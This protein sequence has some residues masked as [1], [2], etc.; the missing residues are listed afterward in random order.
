MPTILI[1]GGSYVGIRVAHSLLKTTA[2]TVP[3]LKVV[4][5]TKNTHF[6]WNMASVRAV[7]PGQFKE[8]QYA[9]PIAKGFEQYPAGSFELIIGSAEALDID[10][11]TV[12]IKVGDAEQPC[13]YD[14]LVLATGSR[15]TNA[16]VPWKANGTY[17]EVAAS[18]KRTQDRIAEAKEIIIAGAGATGIELAGEIAFEYGKDKKVTLLSG[19]EKI[20]GGDAVASN[21][22]NEL[23]K[24]G[25]SIKTSAR[26]ANTTTLTDGTGKTEVT[27][28]N[29]DKLVTDLYLPT[30][31]VVPNSEYIPDKLLN[32]KKLVAVDETY[33]VTGATDV[34]AAGDVVAK[35][36]AT[37]VLADAQA[38]GVAKN[39][40]LVLKGKNPGS[41]SLM[42]F[43][44]TVAAIGRNRGVGRLGVVKLFSF[45][46]YQMK[47]KTLGVERTQTW[48]DGSAF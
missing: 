35:P 2:K 20:L 25:V 32:D 7:I 36:K 39:L 24:L 48:V 18:I 12:T 6:Y 42:P 40:D 28:E 30:M 38:A 4:L 43:D 15:Y 19:G 23:K 9:L 26:V 41:V 10:A 46:V 29:G 17:E 13:T 8:E 5:V 31:G 22:A 34:W 27:L 16:D 3:N 11:K 14:Q 37:F 33:R 21:A 47:G 44:V 1:L 45:L